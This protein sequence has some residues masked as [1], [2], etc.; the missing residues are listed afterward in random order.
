MDYQVEIADYSFNPPDIT[1]SVND[2]VTWLNNDTIV[3]TATR[4]EAPPFDTGAIQPTSTSGP[5]AFI[6]ASPASGFEYHCK[7]HPH[8][9]GRIVVVEEHCLPQTP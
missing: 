1:I 9:R 7:P 4:T 3:H 8:M 6:V 5:I 2:T